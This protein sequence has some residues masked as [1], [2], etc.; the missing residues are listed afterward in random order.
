[1][2]S[3]ESTASRAQ[4]GTFMSKV[5]SLF[6]LALLVSGLGVYTGFHYATELFLTTPGL[7]F[8]IFAVE[9]LL[10]FTSRIWS[11]REP[12]NYALFAFFTFLSGIT[13]VPLLLSFLA[14]FKSFDLIYSALFSSTATFGAAALFGYT[15]KRSLSGLSGFLFMGLI[16]LLVVSIGGIFFPW[17][18]TTEMMVSGFG[19]LL[20]AGYAAVDMNRLKDYPADEYIM[21]A[22]QLYLD[23]FNLFIYILRLTGALSRD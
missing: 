18:N 22:I 16:G 12:Y 20:F 17:G 15:T 10:I 21:A 13:V 5:L 9:L 3:L 8:G 14:E 1:M 19:V 7:I 23:F 2:T 11:K 4:D 6:G